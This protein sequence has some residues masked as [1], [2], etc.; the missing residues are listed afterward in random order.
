MLE[1]RLADVRNYAALRLEPSPGLNAVIGSNGQGKSNLLE[2]VG[3]LAIGKSFRAKRDRELL[4]FGA[5][6]AAIS[7]RAL[8]HG[9][10]VELDFE[11]HVQGL[12]TRK[13]YAVNGETV[14]H[15]EYLGRTRVVAFEPSDLALASG[16]A[17][18]R[19]AFLNAALAQEHPA[20]YAELAT[21]GQTLAQKN[22]LLRGTVAP[23][24]HLLDVYD[25]R[26]AQAGG[27]IMIA[28]RRFVKRLAAHAS[29]AY[30][31]WSGDGELLSVQYRPS[32][33]DETE[34]PQSLA[35]VL[36][37]AFRD[38]RVRERARHVSLVGPHRD[39]LELTLDGRAL[40]VFGS[41]GQRRTAVLALK[42]A[43]YT[44]AC[45]LS[46]DPPILLL[47][48]VLSELDAERRS[49][50]LQGIGSY[51]QAFVSAT[52]ALEGIIPAATF[53]VRNAQVTQQC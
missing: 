2:A 43:E 38:A 53:H 41:Q 33:S 32:V 36:Y 34:D 16:P 5:T 30:R 24:E 11:L 13:R 49:A 4:R 42:I 25:T 47:D 1:L 39:E 15:A 19:R 40:G 28:R 7:G 45:E 31:I 18:V 52:E 20:Y 22:A 29:S 23:D 37:D 10:V 12:T 44:S 17:A 50:F 51:E 35:K 21:Y 9:G 46:G 3:I 14:R 48:D 26:L 8:A 27:H 6:D